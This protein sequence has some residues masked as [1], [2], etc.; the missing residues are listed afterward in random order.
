M[1][2]SF[3][4]VNTLEHIKRIY[5]NGQQTSYQYIGQYIKNCFH[6][7]I[8]NGTEIVIYSDILVYLW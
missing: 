5:V 1:L 6:L 7:N 8:L 4:L 2:P 3:T